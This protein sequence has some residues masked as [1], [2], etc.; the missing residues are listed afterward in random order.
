MLRLDDT[1]KA[2]IRQ[3]ADGRK[4]F[5]AIAE[6]I[7]ITE[8]TVRNRVN[9]MIEEGII[10]ISAHLD[11]Q[12]IPGMQI[13]IMGVKSSTLDLEKKAKELMKLKGVYSA[14][15]V[16]GRYDIILQIVIGTNE[17]DTLLY[18]FKHELGKVKDIS[19]V[20]SFVVYQ[21]HNYRIPYMA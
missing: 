16:T 11:P 9:K 4:A 6:E 10:D 14:A 13:V 20:E 12:Q 17:D 3:L 21:A 7:G 19:S 2:I 18:F 5:S 1:N 8:N 15:V